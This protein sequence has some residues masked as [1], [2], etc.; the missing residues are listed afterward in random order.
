MSDI[1]FQCPFCKQ[2]MDAPASMMG[3]LID[4]PGCGKPI[5]VAKTIPDWKRPPGPMP[6]STT[7]KTK[8]THTHSASDTS[9]SSLET[10]FQ[11]ETRQMIFDEIMGK[12]A[13]WMFIIGVGLQ[14]SSIVLCPFFDREST[15]PVVILFHCGFSACIMA[16]ALVFIFGVATF[17]ERR[18]NWIY[19]VGSLVGP[20]M[21]LFGI[22]I[23]VESTRAHGWL[24]VC[25][26]VLW[27]ASNIKLHR[28]DE[29]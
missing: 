13:K 26:L 17:Q 9:P 20:A 2:P 14:L 27:T 24:M 18:E 5:E 10:R 7:N 4:C 15:F 28:G 21:F 16:V 29:S 11:K 12:I 6:T 1:S 3:Q 25:G 22:Y 8:N 23:P 19:A